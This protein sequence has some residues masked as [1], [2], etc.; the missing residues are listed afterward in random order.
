M[1]RAE[2]VKAEQHVCAIFNN[3]HLAWLPQSLKTF[4]SSYDSYSD[5]LSYHISSCQM[6]VK[7]VLGSLKRSQYLHVATLLD[8]FDAIN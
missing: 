6:S 8:L 1:S 7:C 5:L 3:W 2:S 4:V